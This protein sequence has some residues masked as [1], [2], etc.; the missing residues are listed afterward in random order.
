M[1]YQP[2]V[3]E[4]TELDGLPLRLPDQNAVLLGR[5]VDD[6]SEFAGCAAYYIHGRGSVLLGSYEKHEF[7]PSYT[8]E[9]ESRLLSA[10]ARAFSSLDLETDLSSIGKALV[11]A[12]HFAD[13][14]PLSHKQAH[15]YALREIGEFSR[16]ETATILNIAP[17]TVDTHL[18]RAQEKRDAAENFVRLLHTDSVELLDLESASEAIELTPADSDDIVRRS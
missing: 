16:E 4:E 13:L 15:V 8:I 17:S 10:C 12:W 5:V 18:Q 2:N 9:C 3:S 1:P 11:Q 7:R 14:T 6:D